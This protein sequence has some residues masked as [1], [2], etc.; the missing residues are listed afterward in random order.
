MQF[1]LLVSIYFLKY[2]K[3][4]TFNK[5]GIFNQLIQL[6]CWIKLNPDTDVSKISKKYGIK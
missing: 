5:I 3:F 4:I 6:N 1:I 2:N